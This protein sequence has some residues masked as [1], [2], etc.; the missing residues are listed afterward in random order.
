[1][2]RIQVVGPGCANCTRLAEMCREVID[3]QGL[4]AKVDKVT[5]VEQFADLGVFITP[6]LI[7]NGRVKSSGRLPEKSSLI[8]WFM[9]AMAEN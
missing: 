1:M 7:I 3:E 9:T 5:D 8:Q 2:L 4:E 6:G